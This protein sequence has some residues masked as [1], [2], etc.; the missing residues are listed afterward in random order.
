MLYP[1][2]R[3]LQEFLRPDGAIFISIDD[4]EI[5]SLRVL[6]DEVFGARNFVATIIWQKVYSPKNS[7]KHFSEDHASILVYASAAETWRPHLISRSDE[8]DK[9]YKNPDNDHRGPWKTSDLS[10][11]NFHS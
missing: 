3:L 1:R 2:L 8:Q 10:A 4:N 6:M 9:A 7:A 5:S 11:R